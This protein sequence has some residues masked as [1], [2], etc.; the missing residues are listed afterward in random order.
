MP[1]QYRAYYWGYINWVK[2]G[3]ESV[4]PKVPEVLKEE[5]I[6]PVLPQPLQSFSEEEKKGKE[7]LQI[8]R[9]K[10]T[11]DNDKARPISIVAPL[12]RFIKS[13][14]EINRSN[15]TVSD[16]SLN[17]CSSQHSSFSAIK[18]NSAFIAYIL[19]NLRLKLNLIIYKLNIN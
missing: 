5:L 6:S 3:K 9:K 10:K 4:E 8:P 18:S 16:S 7:T 15:S 11:K 12:P 17:S 1:T 2:S 19:C 13:P 14:I